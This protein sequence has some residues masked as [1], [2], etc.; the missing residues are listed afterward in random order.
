MD[1]LEATPTAEAQVSE[2]RQSVGEIVEA[3]QA[4]AP[5]AGIDDPIMALIRDPSIDLE[6]VKAFLS[7]RR[8]LADE[9]ERKRKDMIA[10][11][12]RR[13][14]NAALLAC[15]KE[16]PI[17]IKN[18]ENTETH[19][20]YST[21]DQIGEAID[22][23]I[24]RHG[25]TPSFY[26]LPSTKEGFVKVECLLAHSGGHERRFEAELPFDV[27][28][29]KGGTTKTQIHGW[30]S[31]TT[32]ARKA[33]TEMIFDIKSKKMD[34]DGNAAGKPK[35]VISDD[36]VAELRSLIIEANPDPKLIPQF[37][38]DMLGYLKAHSIEAMTIPQFTKARA[39]IRKQIADE[40]AARKPDQKGRAV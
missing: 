39:G 18:A 38:E 31:A 16:I 40:Q 1:T 11:Q 32:Y 8:E 9:E 23:I 27:A 19:S 22:H 14:F 25:F 20:Q 12:A 36:Q 33:L 15:K 24:N 13:E 30:K 34:D 17:V 37:I 35:G 6:R 29:P 5:V 26:P 21:L 4:P 3:R 28:G 2:T 10:E 7:L